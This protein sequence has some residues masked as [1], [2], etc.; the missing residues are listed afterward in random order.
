MNTG[1]HIRMLV[2]VVRTYKRVM[3]PEATL[4]FV[5]TAEF[6]ESRTQSREFFVNVTI[7]E[8]L[9]YISCGN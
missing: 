3:L 6:G 5:H 9:E 7:N 8:I 2:S 4:R 1:I